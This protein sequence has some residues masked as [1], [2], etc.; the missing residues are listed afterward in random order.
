MDIRA[1]VTVNP[2]LG[3][4]P[5]GMSEGYGAGMRP[6][7]VRV[8]LGDPEETSAEL[9]VRPGSRTQG[10][11]RSVTVTAPRWQRP[12][13]PDRLLAEAYREAVALANAR[14]ARS[15]AL[16][17][18]LARG[19]WP[20]EDVTRIA[21]TVLMSTPTTLQEVVIAVRTPAMLERWAEALIREG[22]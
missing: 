5:R 18:I 8:L 20:L 9:V 6:P 13:G 22:T 14:G 12:N 11:G 15:M 16:P 3:R 4:N 21:M 19:A 1:R 17:G 7:H 10:D 2:G